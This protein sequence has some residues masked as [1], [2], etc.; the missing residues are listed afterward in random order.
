MK[1]GSLPAFF[2]VREYG[3]VMQEKR[4]EMLTQKETSLLTAIEKA[5]DSHGVE[6][7]TVEVIGAKRAP[8]I[9]VY[10]DTPSGVSF[11]ELS[12]AQAWIGELLDDID[13]FPGAYT[14]E[15]SSP[16]I[17]RPLRTAEHFKRFKGEEA[18]VKTVEPI[19]GSSNFRGE[20]VSVDDVLVLKTEE[21]TVE[22]A[23]D[24][25]RRANLVGKIDLH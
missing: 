25:I 5:A 6:I 23:F 15:V 17:D 22:I 21:S 10:I 16:G 14:L 8:I 13:P 24:N 12:S 3:E 11:N 20:I 18:K 1:V 7:I 2:F 4:G 9:R 19:G